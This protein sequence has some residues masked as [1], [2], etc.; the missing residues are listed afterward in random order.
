MVDYRFDVE[1][2][3]FESWKVD[4]LVLAIENLLRIEFPEIPDDVRV[5]GYPEGS[6]RIVNLETIGDDAVVDRLTS[7][8]D[9]VYGDVMVLG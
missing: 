3:A 9:G 8:A 7:R 1:L 4:A 6:V 5:V 2:L